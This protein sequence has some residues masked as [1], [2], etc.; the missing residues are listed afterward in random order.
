MESNTTTNMYKS[1]VLPFIEYG[2]SFL[3]GSDL[4]DKRKLQRTQN[5]GLKLVLN[6][7]WMYDTDILCNEARLA[8]L[9]TRTD[10]VMIICS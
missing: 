3:L 10:I 6:K 2:N 5:R 7:H 8:S 9:E 4:V 1:M